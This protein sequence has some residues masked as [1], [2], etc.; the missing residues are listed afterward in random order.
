MTPRIL[1]AALVLAVA[2]ALPASASGAAAC[3][4]S[5]TAGGSSFDLV[6]DCAGRNTD[7][8]S[9]VLT[10]TGVELC[11]AQTGT[12]TLTGSGPHGALSGWV[13]WRRAGTHYAVAGTYASGGHGHDLQLALDVAGL[14]GGAVAG[15]GALTS[16]Q[17]TEAE[18]EIHCGFDLL[19]SSAIEGHYAGEAYGVVVDPYGGDVAFRCLL[20]VNGAEVATTPTAHGAGAAVTAGLVEVEL[21][22]TDT[23]EVCGEVVTDRGTTVR[24]WGPTQ[25]S[26]PDPETLR[27]IARVAG[28]AEEVLT[29]VVRP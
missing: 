1:A 28:L 13:A 12:G 8:G 2:P 16:V 4:A 22:D 14:C 9:Y 15:A 11:G 27:R 24:C 26:L 23:L 3:V 19:F 21:W 10:I 7:P 5:G 25:T 6:V 20:R 29:D 17:V 18:P